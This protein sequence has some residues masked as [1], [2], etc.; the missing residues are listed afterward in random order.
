LSY[1]SA[2]EVAGTALTDLVSDGN[3]V[4]TLYCHVDTEDTTG[5]A[6]PAVLVNT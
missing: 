5:Y 1:T 2:D 6:L 3:A 4:S